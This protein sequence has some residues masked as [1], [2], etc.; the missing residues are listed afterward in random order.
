ME[1]HAH[2]HTERKKFK[3]YLWEFL[4]LFLAV[5]L[6][7]FVD[8]QRERY[9]E[10]SRAKEFAALMCD[11]LKK[12]TAF[13]RQKSQELA[14]IKEHQDSLGLMLKIEIKKVSNYALIRQ[15]INSLWALNFTPQQATYEQ[16]KNSG[17]LRYIKNIKLINIMQE[18]YNNALPAIIHWHNIQSELTE[19]RM[20]PFLE[21]HINYQEADFI[22]S[23]IYTTTPEIFDWNKKNAIKLYNMMALLKEQNG[24]LNKN[25][26]SAN[27]KAILLMELLQKEYALK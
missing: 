15:W 24:I 2:T 4:M 21:D 13:F 1:V 10:H 12:D 23:T 26:D 20:I 27:K 3:H 7:F 19:K 6:G 11:D 17:S 18:Y 9:V 5:T 16:M 25:Y 14:M 8:N 22:A